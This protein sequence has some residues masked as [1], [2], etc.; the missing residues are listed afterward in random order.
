MRMPELACPIGGI[1]CAFPTFTSATFACTFLTSDTSAASTTLSRAFLTSAAS[2]TITLATLR[3]P[4][5]TI[6]RAITGAILRAIAGTRLHAIFSALLRAAVATALTT[7][8]AAAV[9]GCVLVGLLTSDASHPFNTRR[10]SASHSNFTSFC[11]AGVSSSHTSLV[12]AFM[13]GLFLFIYHHICGLIEG[14]LDVDSKILVVLQVVPIFQGLQ[15][16]HFR[17]KCA[18]R[19]LVAI[20]TLFSYHQLW[21]RAVP[22]GLPEPR[23]INGGQY[24]GFEFHEYSS[25]YIDFAAAPVIP[26]TEWWREERR[27]KARFKIVYPDS[28]PDRL[29]LS[30]AFLCASRYLIA[31]LGLQWRCASTML[32]PAPPGPPAFSCAPAPHTA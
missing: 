21:A 14:V 10:Y 32:D 24:A 25:P 7:V 16:R 30:P 13:P 12:T 23:I 2:V 1:L 8:H 18:N 22:P 17:V 6:L 5:S 20:C 29:N 15:A 3:A 9:I 19:G 31:H 26:L 27:I 4:A 28:H 11:I